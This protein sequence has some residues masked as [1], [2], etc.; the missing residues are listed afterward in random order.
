MWDFFNSNSNSVKFD[1]KEELLAS[2]LQLGFTRVKLPAMLH[3]S[4]HCC[5]HTI[6]IDAMLTSRSYLNSL[7]SFLEA[8]SES[9]PVTLKH[10]PTIN[11]YTHDPG[12]T[13]G[14]LGDR[15]HH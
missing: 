4:Q 15:H 12:H 13:L 7:N 10:N 8:S 11:S 3:A 6:V 14:L 5:C 1:R 2:K 9:A